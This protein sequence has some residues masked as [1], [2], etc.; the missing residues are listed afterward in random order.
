MNKLLFYF[1]V[2]NCWF[3]SHQPIAWDVCKTK[4]EIREGLS[5]EWIENKSSN[6]N[7]TKGGKQ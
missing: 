2:F 5:K 6:G 3:Y 4:V 7:I 1:K